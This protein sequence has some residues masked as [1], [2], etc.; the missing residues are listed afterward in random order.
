LCGWN[1]LKQ[2]GKKAFDEFVKIEKYKNG[3]QWAQLMIGDFYQNGHGTK[4]DQTKRFEWYKK[5]AEQGNSLAINNLGY[6]YDKGLGVAQNIKKGFEL[7]EQSALLGSSTG[8][9]SVG[10]CYEEG[11][12]QALAKD[13]NNAK[14]WYTKALAQGNMRVQSHLD[15]LNAA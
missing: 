2:D 4:K 13:V 7:Y 8:M 11:R 6:C 9:Y 1:G 12:G 10:I 14:I 3:Y 15:L 5:S